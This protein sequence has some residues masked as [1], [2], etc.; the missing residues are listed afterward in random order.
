RPAGP[1]SFLEIVMRRIALTMFAILAAGPAQAAPANACMDAKASH[2]ARIAGCSAII[3]AKRDTGRAL[4][5]AYCNRG[6]AL[7]E[8]RELDLA[9]ADLEQA[10]KIDAKYAC[11]FSNRGRVWAFKGDLDRAIADYAAAIRLDPRFAI[12]YNNRG[13]AL[14]RQNKV[15]M[16][17]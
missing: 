17:I 12:A 5:I 13:D 9:L 8:K 1:F 3:D 10:I 4:A 16:A 7:T 11:S 14:L 15:E 6:Y 2:D